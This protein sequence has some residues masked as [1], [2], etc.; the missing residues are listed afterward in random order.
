MKVVLRAFAIF[1]E[2]VGEEATVDLPEGATLSDLL[3]EV[4]SAH[5]RLKR[6][7]SEPEGAGGRGMTILLNR[8]G[9]DPS[10]LRGTVLKEGDEVAI[11]P[12]FSGG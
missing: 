10:D 3:E 7:L 2:E 9:A 4:G 8:R 6:V 11:L 12:P 1:R 5:P